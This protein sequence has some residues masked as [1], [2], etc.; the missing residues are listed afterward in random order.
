MV[1]MVQASGKASSVTMSRRVRRCCGGS[2]SQ[3]ATTITG[4]I[5][6][7]TTSTHTSPSCTSTLDNRKMTTKKVIVRYT[8]APA[9]SSSRPRE[10]G[11]SRVA[12]SATKAAT[13]MRLLR[14]VKNAKKRVG[15][16]ASFSANTTAC[17]TIAPRMRRTEPT[18]P[19]VRTLRI[20]IG[21]RW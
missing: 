9:R 7:S 3:S 20:A 13:P 15:W 1:R 21:D 5:L 19:T 16:K 4:K 11:A 12:S 10:R 2:S 14:M 18:R 8:A 17:A 6:C